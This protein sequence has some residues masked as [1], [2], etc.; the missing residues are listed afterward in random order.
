MLL[1]TC[2][3]GAAGL[4]PGAGSVRAA[5]APSA[6]NGTISITSS[7]DGASFTLD[8][9][10]VYS[11]QAPETF[12]EAPAGDYTIRWGAMEGRTTPESETSTLEAGGTIAFRGVYGEPPPETGTIGVTSSPSEAPFSITGARTYSGVTP[13]VFDDAPPGDYSIAWGAMDGY[14]APAPDEGNVA[15]GGTITFR[16]VYRQAPPDT[17]TIRVTSS[18]SGASFNITGARAY[19]GVTPAVF[20]DAP[21]GN[22]SIAWSDMAG[23]TTPQSETSTLEAGGT[24]TFSGV[25]GEA[26]PETGTIR[27]T[28]SPSGAF[29]SITGARQ[30]SGVTPAVFSDAPPG[31]YSIAW[32]AM[33]GYTAPPSQAGTLT[34]G[35]SISLSGVYRQAPAETG[36]IRVT[37]SPSGA[38]FSITGARAYSGVTPAVFSDAPPGN[39]SIAWGA[40]AGYTAPPSQASTLTAGGSV[41][42]AG[43]YG[44]VAPGPTV[45][46]VMSAA[47]NADNATILW[48]TDVPA[49]GQVQYGMTTSYGLTTAVNPGLTT[50]HSV[51]LGGLLYATFY[52]YRVISADAQGNST[53]SGDYTFTTV[54]NMPPRISSAAVADITPTSCNI[55]WTTDQPADSQVEYGQT[56][57]YGSITAPQPALLTSH[58]VALIGLS[59]GT[60]YYARV[61]SRDRAGNLAQSDRF[62]FLTSDGAPPVISSVIITDVSPTSVTVRWETDERA[63][64]AVAYGVTANYESSSP[65]DPQLIRSHTVS[66]TG[67]APQTTYHYRVESRDYWGNL[68]RSPDATFTTVDLTAPL[69]SKVMAT[70]I[71]DN[72]AAIVWNTDS[73]SDGV[74]EYGV[75]TNY[76]AVSAYDNAMVTSHS[77]AISGLTA[78]TAYH[79]KVKS[80]DASGK[81]TES[82]DAIFTTGVDMGPDPPQIV[83]LHYTSVTSSGITIYW[84][85]DEMATARVEYGLTREYGSLSSASA[86]M[87]TTHS[88]NL[89][90]LKAGTTYH[91][92]A[93]STDAAGNLSISQDGTFSTPIA[94]APLPSL[95]PWAWATAFIAGAMLVGV[96]VV[97]NR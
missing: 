83:Y 67:L 43:T 18:P 85:T 74:V 72:S 36:T 51:V 28:S 32:S 25:Y 61:L 23:R 70:Q 31:N 63:S 6:D 90:G 3:P 10:R 13:A 88:V 30:Y 58:R 5:L 12:D 21:P 82:A 54:D 38:F 80:R 93:W 47:V 19:S 1:L 59:P 75:S 78:Q 69:I 95:P 11:G 71:S 81:W 97:K 60:W 8:G 14:T 65:V 86:Q 91:Y 17:G 37:S 55:T 33:A 77:V 7:P 22:Y 62:E 52:H 24:I 73:P 89:S 15:A 48:T 84:D 9:P 50:S 49:T 39:Y 94:R 26:P 29:F 53:T 46:G 2:I 45:S 44:A 35:G 68:T 20:S 16:G 76:G 96:L 92:R 64:S 27:V 87:A 41:S 66:L 34:A 42:F 40:M 4:A 79:F 57:E 56:V